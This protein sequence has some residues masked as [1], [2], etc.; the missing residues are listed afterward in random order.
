MRIAVLGNSPLNIGVTAA[1]DL[2]ALGHEVTLMPFEGEA[3]RLD[4]VRDGVRL[5]ASKAQ[6]LAVGVERARFSLREDPASA[7]EGVEL[8]ILDTPA[9]ALEAR[10]RAIAPHL[11][12]GLHLH[13]D[14]H[15][16][17]PALRAANLPEW[18]RGRAVTLSEGTTPTH[19]GALAGDTVEFHTVRRNIALGVF[20][21]VE[22]ERVAALLNG[23]MPLFVPSRDVLATNLEGMNFLVHPAIALVNAGAFDRAEERGEPIGFYGEANTAHAARLGEA[24]DA[25]R[26]PLETMLELPH[27]PLA[28][29]I[30]ALYGGGGA[31][32][33]EAIAN[34]P[35]YKALPPL[36]ADVWRGWM[37]ADVP[38]THVPFVRLAGAL[39]CDAPLHR[40]LV[41]LMGAM[42][43]EDF[44]S[45]GL[46]LDALGLAGRDAAAMR[47]YV[48]EG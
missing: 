30:G 20:P 24:L 42:L 19:A 27:R 7:L 38:L 25:E 29:Q 2:A 39:G 47:R 21:A 32:L 46:T 45:G 43:G 48:R 5:D 9:L 37:R 12:A 26:I 8:A 36:R 11:P 33:R 22:T 31:T 10:I 17:W 35:F 41:D 40:G 16:Y 44:W 1:T 4:G 23:V 14:T 28:E 34:A 6:P 18:P 15:G 3:E 13:V